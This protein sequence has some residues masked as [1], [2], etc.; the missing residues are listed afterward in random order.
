MN[1]S[2]FEGAV[3][4][5]P[6]APK[7]FFASV[8]RCATSLASVATLALVVVQPSQHAHAQAWTRPQGEVFVSASYR[9][10]AGDT[11]YAP[12]GSSVELGDTYRQHTGNIYA[13]GGVIDRWLTL[14]YN[15]ELIRRNSLDDQ[16]ATLGI[17]DMQVGAWTGL[18]TKP[19]RLS[20]GV[21]LGLPTGDP[22]P[23][24][25]SN[26]DTDSR[27]TART[28]P[29]GDGEF[30]LQYLIS[31]G[32]GLNFAGWPLSHYIQAKLGFWHRFKG[33][34]DQ[35]LYGAEFGTSIKG[36]PWNRLL[37][38]FRLDAVQTYQDRTGTTG[39]P[40][41]LGDGV[42]YGAIGAEIFVRIID[43]WFLGAG[44]DGAFFGENVI[45]AP[46][47]KFSLAWQHNFLK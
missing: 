31:A 45:A 30:D 32:K 28:L 35:L 16:G 23:D 40:V 4:A 36:E 42:S 13:A 22:T 9:Y 21:R 27:L 15:G 25:G 41:G 20:A 11:F 34:R 24:A 38:I 46:Q 5:A 26:A 33:F 14:E 18:I 17:G 7:H 1:T 47:F 39:T 2:P 3:T 44:A 43:K 6:P 37:L 19:F 10:V 8:V 29:T 12:D